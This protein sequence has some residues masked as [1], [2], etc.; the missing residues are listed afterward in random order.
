MIKKWL[1]RGVIAA[2]IV[3]VLGGIFFGDDFLSYV[4][5]SIKLTQETAKEAV[6]VEFELRRAKDLLEEI[7][8]EMHTNVRMIAAEEVEIA[9]LKQELEESTES[10]AV[11]KGKVAKLR[12]A[13]GENKETYTFGRNK[14][15]RSEVTEELGWR[16]ERLKEAQIVLESKKRLLAARERSLKSAMGLLEKTRSQKRILASKIQGLE[17]QHRLVK[18]TAIGTGIKV[19]NSKL[20]QTEE[21]IGE[22]KKRLDVAERILSHQSHFV[23]LSEIDVLD[24]KELVQKV[25]EYMDSVASN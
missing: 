25:D 6:P 21:L 23:Q 12:K 19:D 13:I 24:E 1:K 9:G 5:S 20:M 10:V 16:F 17:S 14:Y 11:E 4:K 3:L 2:L 7:I 22:I 15:T 8:P 18:A